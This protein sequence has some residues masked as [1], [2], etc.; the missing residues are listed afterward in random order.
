MT[1]QPPG[2]PQPAHPLH[3]LT[4]FELTAYQ[5]DLERALAALPPAAPARGIVQGKLAE[6]QAEQESRARITAVRP[7]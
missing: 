3:A 7:A 1:A 4:T 6:I 2:V 5:R